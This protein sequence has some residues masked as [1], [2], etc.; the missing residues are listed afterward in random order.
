VDVRYFVGYDWMPGAG[1]ARVTHALQGGNDKL[2]DASGILIAEAL[3]SNCRVTQ[4]SLVSDE[5]RYFV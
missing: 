2:T 4:V 5:G 3:K 1:G